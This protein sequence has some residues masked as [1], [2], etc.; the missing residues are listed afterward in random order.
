MAEPLPIALTMGEPAGI[1]GEL[2][3]K[4]WLARPPAAGAFFVIADPAALI[5]E[6]TALGLDVPIREITTPEE[7]VDAFPHA[8]PVLAEPLAIPATPG[9]PNIANAPAVIKAI[10]RAVNL[11]MTSQ[12]AALV[13]NP[14]HKKLLADSGFPHPGHTEYLGE[15]TGT[16]HPVM[17]LACPGLKVVPV[18]VHMALRDAIGALTTEQIV[19]AGSITAQALTNDFG[20]ANPRLAVAALN[21]HAGDGGLLGSEDAHL[22]APAVAQLKAQG[23]TVF[24]PVPADTLF[25]ERARATY[26]AAVCMYH[27][28]ALIPLKTID[29]DCGVDVTL[30]LPI[31]RTSP[32]HGTAFDIAGQGVARESSL[33]A[34]LIL[35]RQIAMNRANTGARSTSA[36]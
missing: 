3:L 29:F 1:G 25:H 36:H 26:D 15:L 16:V 33:I 23:I 20:I 2:T 31:V 6:A 10:A 7:A 19:I 35:A 13:T 22:I 5:Y 4:T 30:G 18:T 17:M 24:G 27:D 32:D 11:A 12:V 14:I 21:P 34:A 8:L 28:Q 9:Q